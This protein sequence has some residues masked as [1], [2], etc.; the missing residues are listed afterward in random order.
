MENRDFELLVERIER[1]AHARPGVYKAQV[2]GLAVLGYGF[3]AVVVAILAAL[4]VAAVLAIRHAPLLA[5]KFVIFIGAFLLVVL[6]ALWVKLEPPK[7]WA[8]SHGDAP[9]LFRLLDQLRK[10]LQTPAIHAVLVTPDFNA[11][12]CQ[13]PRLGLFGWH[14]NYLLLGLPLLQVLTRE[15]FTA[16]VAHELGH[17]SHGHARSSNWIYRLRLTWLR[18]GAALR[19]HAP[20]GSQVISW[21]YRWYV[22]YFFAFSFPLARAN[23]FEA[24]EAAARLTSPQIASQA[25]TTVSVVAAFLNE[26]YWPG[27]LQA[28]V[29][30]PPRTNFAP[31]SG[32]GAAALAGI[33]ESDRRNW[34]TAALKQVASVSDSHPSLEERLQ[35]MGGTPEV[36][37]PAPGQA[38]DLL[39]RP[40]LPRLLAAFD[41]RWHEQLAQWCERQRQ[42]QP[43]QEVFAPAPPR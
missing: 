29:D 39:L 23:E 31:Y 12:I 9:D 4:A 26:R 15:Q 14:R 42:K 19:Q 13:I 2:F 20:A 1:R 18:L 35:A 36:A 33:S 40:A 38:A 30:A 28:A 21:F 8:L 27:I 22:P 32:L 3:L 17:L 34:V 41:K 43:Q 25:L 37:V 10:E 7:G 24:D 11:G 16:V 6:R 5:V